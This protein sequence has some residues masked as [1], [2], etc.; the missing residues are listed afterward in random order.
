MTGSEHLTGWRLWLAVVKNGEPMLIPP[1]RNVDEYIAAVLSRA[2]CDVEPA[3]DAPAD[4]CECGFWVTTT[5]ASLVPHAHLIPTWEACASVIHEA[6]RAEDTG[7]EFRIPTPVLAKVRAYGTKPVDARKS[8]LRA[9][10]LIWAMFGARQKT[11]RWVPEIGEFHRAA[12][13]KID[14]VLYAKSDLTPSEVQTLKA[15][16]GGEWEQYPHIGVPALV[17]RQVPLGDPLLARL[18]SMGLA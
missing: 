14:K 12:R 2:V 13:L 6:A 4:R 8:D 7:E 3:H 11:K 15:R 10:P 9:N 1:Y 5:P 17:H 18:R 16:Y